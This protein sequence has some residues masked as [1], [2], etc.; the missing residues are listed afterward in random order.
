MPNLPMHIFIAQQVAQE[1]DWG[2]VHD[3]LGS[4]FL[5]STT[6]DIRAMTKW[7]RELTHFAP[8]TL[9]SVGTGT[10]RMFELYPELA[11]RQNLNPATL[12]FVLGY[13]SHLTADEVWIT[14]M[15]R[16]HFSRDNTVAGSEMEAQI[17]DRALQLDMDRRAHLEMDGLSVAGDAICEGEQVVEIEFI[18]AEVLAEWRQWVARFMGWEFD[19]QR[20][21]RAMSRMYRDNDDVQDMVDLFLSDMPQSLE[22]VY[23]KVPRERVENYRQTAVKQT[24]LQIKEYLGEV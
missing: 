24:L 18:R 2:F 20:L 1:L 5:G 7:D 6:P 13:V 16:P 21:K 9:E 19:W 11:D 22:T 8:L 10:Q 4:C 23:E 14:T 17:W 3:N 12:A 15:F